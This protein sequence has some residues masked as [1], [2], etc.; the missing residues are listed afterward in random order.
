[1]NNPHRLAP[2]APR[3]FG[4][5]ALDRSAKLSFR[6]N[7]RTIEGYGGDTVLT[8]LLASG[9]TSIGRF[10]D[11]PL[12]LSDRL[13]PLVAGK[14]GEFLPSDRL[15]ARDGLELTTPGYRPTL[16][17]RG[18]LLDGTVDGIPE[19]PWLRSKPE[20]T[21]AADLLVVGGGVAGLAAAE[22]AASAGSTVVLVER[23][24]WLGGDAR[25]FGPVGDEPSPDAVTTDLL[26]RLGALPNVTTFTHAEVF[27]LAGTLAHFHHISD[28]R[29]AVVAVNARRLV[30]ATGS[31]QRLPV[32]TGNR[33]PGVVSAMSAY[34]LA[35][36]YGVAIGRSAIVATGSNYGYRLA[37]RFHDAGVRI[38]RIVDT[39][40]NPQS[41]FV[42]F[43]K[44]SGLKLAGG[45]LPLSASLDRAG[46]LEVTLADMGSTP[47][48]A[49][50]AT[51]SLIVS[52][53]FQPDLTLW[54][55]AGGATQWSNGKLVAYGAVEDV[56]VAG[57]AANFRSLKACLASGRDA[58]AAL[59]GRERI[60]VEDTEIGAPYETPEVPVSIAPPTAGA[61]AFL[62][63]GLSLIVR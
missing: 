52:G 43:A 45:Q 50:L 1:M 20:R 40:V 2:D 12:A 11:S 42:D 5:I 61:P 32:F 24:P 55:Q 48:S 29:G 4:G 22:A 9:V 59:F 23:R 14:G 62:D 49:P 47:G 10:A 34:H 37:L 39:R 36:R 21:V 63:G 25:Y 44:A 53:P 16:L 38:E 27:A 17:R 6:L 33:L 35:K 3:G 41:R 46:K 54:L 19:P 18:G 60:A 28:G 26:A 57:A 51:E 31:T 15:P 13:A 8:A 58:V 7:G 56:A 30:L